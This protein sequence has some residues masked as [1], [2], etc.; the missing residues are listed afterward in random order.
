MKK[1]KSLCFSG[2][3]VKEYKMVIYFRIKFP[4]I[5]G[6]RMKLNVQNWIEFFF[7]NLFQFALGMGG[8]G[9]RRH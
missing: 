2:I 1:K 5:R 7:I 3:S 9:V 6:F 8:E 4:F